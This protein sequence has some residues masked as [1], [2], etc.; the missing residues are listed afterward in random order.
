MIVTITIRTYPDVQA[1]TAA[2]QDYLNLQLSSPG[3]LLLL[4]PAQSG[5]FCLLLCL[6]QALSTL[7]RSLGGV[8]TLRSTALV[9]QGKLVGL[10]LVAL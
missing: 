7:S 2:V 1:R 4:F 9:G 5:L 3:L 6:Q 10:I 8:V